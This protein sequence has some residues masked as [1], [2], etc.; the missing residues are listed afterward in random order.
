M[1]MTR[2]MGLSR[3]ERWLGAGLLVVLAVYSAGLW[4]DPFYAVAV[5][6]LYHVPWVVAAMLA[7]IAVARSHG[8]ERWAWAL[9]GAWAWTWG[10]AELT[11]TYYN[12]FAE[13]ELPFP[14]LPEP[15]Y[16]AGYVAL[17]CAIGLF[18]SARHRR[19]EARG[20]LD[21]LTLF[22][23][24]GTLS[25]QFIVLPLAES[26][27]G[28][29][30]AAAAAVAY[31][32][33]DLA[34]ATTL[35]MSLYLSNT[36]V[37]APMVMI[38]LVVLAS[39]VGDTAYTLL[40]LHYPDVGTP[41]RL[42][43]LAWIATYG[44]MAMAFLSGASKPTTTGAEGLKRD[45]TLG[46]ALPYV[47]LA[48]LATVTIAW[49]LLGREATV[50]AVGVLLAGTVMMVRQWLTLREN[51]RLQGDIR[52]EME[53]R[54]RAIRKQEM[55]VEELAAK[56]EE[57]E[58]ARAE[59]QFLADH[60]GLTG[61][62][63]HRAWFR[64]AQQQRPKAMVVFDIDHFKQVND[65]F[66]HPAGDLVL[67][68]VSQRLQE[69]LGGIGLLGRLGGEEFGLLLRVTAAEAAAVCELAVARLA[70][71][72]VGLPSGQLVRLTVSA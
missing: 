66:G 54:T 33:F 29:G 46:L 65:S 14:G 62:L 40:T 34:L 44:F 67:R 24:V 70:E 32:V 60:D 42:L 25:Y 56:A 63:N 47:A 61:L 5:D 69:M 49:L 27:E 2:G 13:T 7:P 36:R 10:A 52:Q 37:G 20:V 31:P 41:Y 19:S 17:A 18:A 48:P 43:D 45:S 38:G 57:L 12:R 72:P 16:F 4:W 9:A 15:L 64:E 8:R 1:T 3:R 22:I 26:M 59:A 21:G 58:R 71:E 11:Y 28:G 23:V 53:Q 6:T 50:L 35:V 68:Q 39:L 55:L 30:A 51:L